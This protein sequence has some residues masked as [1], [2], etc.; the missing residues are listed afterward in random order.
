MAMFHCAGQLECDNLW[1]WM[2]SL[3]SFW[4]SVE[5]CERVYKGHHSIAQEG[6]REAGVTQQ[7]IP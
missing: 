1:S 2:A 7:G 3:A 4:G 6:K 5:S